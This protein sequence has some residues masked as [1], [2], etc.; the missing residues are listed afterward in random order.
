MVN[1]CQNA[2]LIFYRSKMKHLFEV[3]IMVVPYTPAAKGN[4]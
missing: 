2:E 1:S 3:E 4:E